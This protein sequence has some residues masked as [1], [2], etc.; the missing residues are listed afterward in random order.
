MKSQCPKGQIPEEPVRAQWMQPRRQPV[1][2]EQQENE[3]DESKQ[4]AFRFHL[5]VSARFHPLQLE[6]FAQALDLVA[7][8]GD[9]SLL[10]VVH[11]QYVAACEPRNHFLDVVN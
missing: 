7:A 5:R 10:F 6:E 1:S 4:R 9:F 8:D 2:Y 11:F 3:Y